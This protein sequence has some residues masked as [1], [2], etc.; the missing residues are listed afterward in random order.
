MENVSL[1][2]WDNGGEGRGERRNWNWL[3]SSAI[4]P[5]SRRE[6]IFCIV[7]FLERIQ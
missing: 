6:S 5:V 2:S 1:Y 7:G 4:K 3:V